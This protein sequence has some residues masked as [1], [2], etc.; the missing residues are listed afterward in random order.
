MVYQPIKIFFTREF[1]VLQYHGIWA[2]LH[3]D[4]CCLILISLLSLDRAWWTDML[5]AW[6]PDEGGGGG[7][8]DG[9]GG[10]RHKLLV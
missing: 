6:R 3:D 10:W 2:I 8:T 9:H 5:E 1:L 7:G 4:D